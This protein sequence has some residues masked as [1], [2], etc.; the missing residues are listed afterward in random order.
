MPL[1]SL[2]HQ[3]RQAALSR[4]PRIASLFGYE[5]ILINKASLNGLAGGA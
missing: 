1:S 4:P 2:P 5:A 3:R